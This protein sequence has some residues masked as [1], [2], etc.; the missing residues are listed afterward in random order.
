[1]T[2][3][4]KVMILSKLHTRFDD[5]KLLKVHSYI[6]VQPKAAILKHNGLK[7]RFYSTDLEGKSTIPVDCISQNLCRVA[8]YKYINF[9]L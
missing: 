5:Q 1:M 9:I 2:E 6:D 3:T 8:T 7:N 4:G